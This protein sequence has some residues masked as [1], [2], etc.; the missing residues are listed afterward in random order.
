V[1]AAVRYN[2]YGQF[3]NSPD[4]RRLGMKPESMRR[5]IEKVSRLLSRRTE[6]RD[7]DYKEILLEA[8]EGDLVYMDPPYQGVCNV[9]DNR[10]HSGIDHNEFV[11][12]LDELAARDVDFIVSYDGRTGNKVHGKKLPSFLGLKRLEIVVGRSTQATLL[13]RDDVTAESIYLS[14][15][16]SGKLGNDPIMTAEHPLI[17]ACV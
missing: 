5:N 17:A 13:G 2:Q 8:G 4:K 16:L 12:A 11:E 7:T 6:V 3:N 15:S 10:Y 1:K 9:R 14:P